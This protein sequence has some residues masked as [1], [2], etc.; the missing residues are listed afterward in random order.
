MGTEEDGP[1]PAAR[2][3]GA[4]GP[5]QP[6]LR[7]G[8]PG[9]APQ[10]HPPVRGDGTGH[11]AG[12]RP[13]LQRCRLRRGQRHLRD[14]PGRRGGDRRHARR[15][16][17]GGSAAGLPGDL[18]VP[19]HGPALHPQTRRPLG[20]L[21]GPGNARAGSERRGPGHRPAPAHGRGRP[22]QRLQ[23]ADHGGPGRL[24]V[25][26]LPRRLPAGPGQRGRRPVPGPDPDRGPGAAEHAAGR[27]ARDRDLRHHDGD[28]LGAQRGARRDRRV[29]AR[30]GRAADR[31]V[32]SGR[33]LPQPVYAAR[34]RAPPGRP[35]GPLPGR[36]ARGP[37]TRRSGT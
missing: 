19:D 2:G 36:A 17:H 24:P 34:R 26:V 33:V 20:R 18:R 31:G 14:R 13:G 9:R 5:A 7:A 25:R 35:V 30:P 23:P 12:L 16:E 10:P 21:A 29:A 11:G 27:P 28:R 15:G 4:G 22:D 3:Q 1:G 37:T 6:R 32:H 8:E